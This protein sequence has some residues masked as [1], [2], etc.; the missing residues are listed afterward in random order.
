M[1]TTTLLSVEE[2]LNT[3]YRPDVDFLEGE[4]LERNMGEQS[5]GLLQGALNTIFDVNRKAW[6][7]RTVPETRLQ[8]RP[9][10]YRIPDVMVLRRTDPYEEIVTRSP[11]LCIE[12]LSKRD[13]LRSIQLRV[14]DYAAMGVENVWVI[15]PWKR[16]AYYGSSNGYSEPVPDSLT[17]TGTPV[18]VSVTELFER[19]DEDQ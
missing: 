8:V 3:T 10:R 19:L 1:S 5:H 13:T 15:D 17:I 6:G 18:S 12:V 9:D 4:L 16:L 7:V 11:L 2:Y 14:D